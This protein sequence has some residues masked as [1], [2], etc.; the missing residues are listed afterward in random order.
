MYCN[1]AL[2]YTKPMIANYFLIAFRKLR[3]TPVISFIHVFGLALGITSFIFILQY[4]SFEKSV[5][6]FHQN[7]GQLHRGVFQS[8]EGQA[9]DYSPP[10]LGPLL[11]ENLP[12]VVDYCRVAE[13]I[14]N[15]IVNVVGE[16]G[17]AS[18]KETKSAY[19]D[20]S[21]FSMFSFPLSAGS[22][23][24]LYESNTVSISKT[25]AQ[26]YFG[27]TNCI[28]KEI[29]INNEFGENVYTIV[30]VHKDFPENSTLRFDLVLS[31][32]TLAI[33]AN[34]HGGDWADLNGTS[35]YLTTYV[36]LEQGTD[37]GGLASNANELKKKLDPEDDTIFLLQSLSAVHI[38]DS[39]SDQLPHT[40]SLAAL[41]ILSAVAVLILL[42]AWL[43]YVNLST[44]G[45]LQ[46]A[47]EVGLRKVVG[48]RQHQ[49]VLQFLGESFI[50][51]AIAIILGLGLVNII[52]G[53]FNHFVNKDLSLATL[54]ASDLWMWALLFLVA[55]TF[56]SGSYTAF[57]LSSF[58]PVHVL[59]G[60]FSKSAKGLAMRRILV[61]FQFSISIV[62]LSSTL[63]LY[64]QLSFMQNESLGMNI[65][66]LLVIHGPKAELDSTYQLRKQSFK[67]ALAEASFISAYCGS[68]SVPTNGY[69]YSTN[70]ITRLNPTPGDEKLGYSIVYIDDQFLTTYQIGLVAG[71]NFT[72]EEVERQSKQVLLNQRALEQLG[73]DDAASAIGKKIKWYDSEVEVK[74]VVKDYHHLSLKTTIDPVIFL[75]QTSSNFFTVRLQ[76][77]NLQDNIAYLQ[78]TFQQF[79]PGNPFDYF[80]ARD[81]YERQYST[82][83]QYAN[84]F[85]AASLLAIIIASMGLYGLTIFSVDQRTKE[86][87]IRKVLGASTAQVVA[88]IS[89]DFVVLLLVALAIAT[90]IAWYAMDQWIQQFAYQAPI[91][92][93]IF[94]LAGALCLVLALL[95]VGIKA[96][97][98]ASK[99]PVDSLRAE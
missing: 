22:L 88:L 2:F 11:K 95:T 34:L 70:F 20:G 91:N 13:G 1:C 43:N 51:N 57:A 53:T 52:Q 78:K 12:G 90:P 55:G 47:R 63:I 4:V 35:S 28:G 41:Y 15:G 80:I 66:Q 68:A 37:P 71:S 93:V 76:N 56:A 96:G 38:A 18:F 74:G 50:V 7:I 54:G 72:R 10:I 17:P 26:R 58:K 65:D 24:G 21:F 60:V 94:I 45:A 98:A 25:T 8:K 27:S 87:G 85:T 40:G 83:Q 69:N 59:K 73:F 23:K 29:K 64:K 6:Q 89:K 9:F 33:P 46:R 75:P 61:V 92:L 39:L 30:S 62:L 82:E 99:N 32:Q 97:T 77:Q 14:A 19:V 16:N 36:Q 31:I 3:K 49:L 42:I 44:A 81:N 86:L 84:V 67:N 5:N 48:A 79:F